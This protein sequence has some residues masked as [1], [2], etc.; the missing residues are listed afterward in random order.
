ML[1]LIP[2]FLTIIKDKPDYDSFTKASMCLGYIVFSI[3]L[4][5]F[6]FI[7]LK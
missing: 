6:I 1:Y 7:I 2:A 4:P 5:Y 3:I